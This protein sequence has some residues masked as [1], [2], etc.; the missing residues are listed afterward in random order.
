MSVAAHGS[1]TCSAGGASD[2]GTCTTWNI[3]YNPAAPRGKSVTVTY[4]DCVTL[5]EATITVGLGSTVSQCATRQT[6]VSSDPG[7]GGA[8]ITIS[9]LTCTP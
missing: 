3:V 8:T 9:N 7:D 4:I 1:N 5:A 6:P 2:Q